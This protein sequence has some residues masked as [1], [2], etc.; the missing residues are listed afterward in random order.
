VHFNK[1]KKQSWK[2]PIERCL[3]QKDRACAPSQTGKKASMWRLARLGLH[4]SSFFF[5]LMSF[6]LKKYRH[7]LCACPDS[8]TGEVIKN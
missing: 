2:K 8:T 4:A 3:G 5:F 7:L 6:Y 1:N